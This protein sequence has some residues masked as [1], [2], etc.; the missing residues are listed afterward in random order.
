VALVVTSF[1]ITSNKEHSELMRGDPSSGLRVVWDGG[2]NVTDCKGW[3]PQMSWL[4]SR[5]AIM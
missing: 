1:L 5:L 4:S 2:K 3:G